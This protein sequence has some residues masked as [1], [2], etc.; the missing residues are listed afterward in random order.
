MAKIRIGDVV[1]ADSVIA[2]GVEASGVVAVDPITY[3]HVYIYAPISFAGFESAKESV[4]RS[5]TQGYFPD[6]LPI[7]FGGPYAQRAYIKPDGSGHQSTPVNKW[8]YIIDYK[9]ATAVFAHRTSAEHRP[10]EYQISQQSSRGHQ[11]LAPHTDASNQANSVTLDQFRMMAGVTWDRVELMERFSGDYKILLP[12][13]TRAIE[14]LCFEC[15]Y[16]DFM[17]VATENLH[18]ANF[19]TRHDVADTPFIVRPDSGFWTPGM[20]MTS[21]GGNASP[22]SRWRSRLNQFTRARRYY[23]TQNLGNMKPDRYD[24]RPRY[25]DESLFPIREQPIS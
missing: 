21:S 10:H 23:D 6:T 18:H 24:D 1:K 12:S 13:T 17:R 19:K 3:W 16:S 5:I 8:P 11:P 2:D 25:V 4:L 14:A 22:E 7:L 20:N 9:F 15:N